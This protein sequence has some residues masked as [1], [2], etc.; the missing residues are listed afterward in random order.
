MYDV[1]YGANGLGRFVLRPWCVLGN[2][3]TDVGRPVYAWHFSSPSN[4][5]RACTTIFLDL[6]T[7]VP[8]LM[9]K[10]TWLMY[11]RRLMQKQEPD[12]LF[13]SNRFNPRFRSF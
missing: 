8:R 13:E 10:I 6:I 1:T 5:S 7:A 12:L 11:V 9:K 3:R 4:D 2:D